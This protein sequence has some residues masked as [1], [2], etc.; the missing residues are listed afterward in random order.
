MY[1]T[2]QEME[3]YTDVRRAL[4]D[5]KVKKEN[6][7]MEAV[8]GHK[9]EFNED[10]FL[11]NK[12]CLL[13][14][15]VD[16]I[17]KYDLPKLR[18]TQKTEKKTHKLNAFADVLDMFTHTTMDIFNNMA[19]LRS[20]NEEHR[21]KMEDQLQIIDS[22]ILHTIGDLRNTARGFKAKIPLCT[23]AVRDVRTGANLLHGRSRGADFQTMLLRVK[24]VS[25][26]TPHGDYL[27]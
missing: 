20:D 27:S 13:N 12:M 3:N 10:E 6:L 8:Y 21:E 7:S 4:L 24:E 19:Q 18:T 1:K 2:E 5:L 26:T 14:G 11:M 15:V 22:L 16:H 25:V 23:W 17:V 9:S